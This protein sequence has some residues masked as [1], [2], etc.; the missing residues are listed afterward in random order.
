MTETYAELT[1]TIGGKRWEGV[2]IT[3][4]TGKNLADKSTQVII[5]FKGDEHNHA[6]R[7]TFRI[8]PNEGIGLELIVKRPGFDEQTE[9][10]HM[11]F[12]YHGVFDEPAHPEAYERV[13]A[14]AIRG[15]RSLF[16][17]S[18]EVLAAWR[19]VQP[20]LTHWSEHEEGLA[21][22]EP[23]SKGPQARTS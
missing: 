4:S 21:F 6:N 9:R 17:T 3:L 1:T 8:Q 14:D 10:T 23:G 12:S 16:A 19:V 15:D 7:L 22:Y 13:F 2:P 18:Q 20:V 11:D 5:T